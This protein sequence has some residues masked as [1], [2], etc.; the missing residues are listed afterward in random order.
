MQH[1]WYE[2]PGWRRGVKKRRVSDEKEAT[3]VLGGYEREKSFLKLTYLRTPRE[4]FINLFE[5]G[6][7]QR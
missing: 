7:Q 3:K 5:M 1:F 6:V 2:L 4:L